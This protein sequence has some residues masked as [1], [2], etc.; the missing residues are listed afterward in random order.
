MERA[1]DRGDAAEQLSLLEPEEVSEYAAIGETAQV[2]AVAIDRIFTR[3]L[4]EHP[5]DRSRIRARYPHVPRLAQGLRRENGIAAAARGPQPG[6]DVFGALAITA[7]ERDDQRQ[8]S[9][10]RIIFRNVERVIRPLVIALALDESGG[11]GAGCGSGARLCD[12]HQEMHSNH[13]QLFAQFV[14][15]VQALT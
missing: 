13:R 4:L 12:E 6:P 14:E 5:D 1:G 11:D 3:N 2:D 8:R 15:A 9:L 10:G 7:V